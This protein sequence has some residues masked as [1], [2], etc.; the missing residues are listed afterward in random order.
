MGEVVSDGAAEP[1]RLAAT[2]AVSVHGPAGVLDLVVPVGA[3]PVDVARAYADQ[4]GRRGIP[5]LQTPL[6]EHLRA[7][8]ALASAASS[9]ARC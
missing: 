5:L 2:I 6:G 8:R 7:D 3:T 1:S 4:A 9:P